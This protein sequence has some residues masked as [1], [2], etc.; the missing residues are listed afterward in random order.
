MPLCGGFLGLFRPVSLGGLFSA[1]HFSSPWEARVISEEKREVSAQNDP[2]SFNLTDRSVI[3]PAVYT[4]RYT[5]RYTQG[6]IPRGVHLP[7]VYR[8]HIQDGVY[9]SYHTSPVRGLGSVSLFF[10]NKCVSQA[11]HAR[12][13]AG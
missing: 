1:P 12:P 3:H 11:I 9:F 7:T 13:V 6:G 4:L 2:L 10:T 8:R 5:L